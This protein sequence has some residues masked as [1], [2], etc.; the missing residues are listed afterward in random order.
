MYL[1]IESIV[2]L[3][4]LSCRGYLGYGSV[5]AIGE[6]L[7]GALSY[8]LVTILVH[9]LLQKN[10][11]SKSLTGQRLPVGRGRGGLVRPCVRKTM[12]ITMMYM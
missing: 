8:T 10:T 12:E 2:C 4:S 3:L 9:G 5:H 6:L 1:R 11:D 7:T